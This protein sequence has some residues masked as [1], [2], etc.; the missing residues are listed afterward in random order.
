MQR[1][2]QQRMTTAHTEVM[3]ATCNFHSQVRKASPG[4]AQD[5]LDNTT[6]LDTSDDIFNQNTH[7][8]DNAIEAL[9]GKTQRLALWLF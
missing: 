8:G 9:I 1:P 2:G 5:I 7:T 6:T 4:V 3:K